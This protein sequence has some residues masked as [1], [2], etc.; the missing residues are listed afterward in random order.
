M[1]QITMPRGDIHSISFSVTSGESTYTDFDEIYFTVKESFT[2]KKILF[3]K[4]LSDGGIISTNTEYRFR[5]EPEDTNNLDY[6]DY[7]F[8][9]ELVQGN[10]IKQT[11]VGKLTIT[12]EVT[13]ASN[14]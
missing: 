2:N 9:I 11:S 7:V 3:Q 12:E 10:I 1:L 5:I 4:K 14:E 6:G 8:D 13:F